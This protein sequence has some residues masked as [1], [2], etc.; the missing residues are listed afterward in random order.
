MS[1]ILI[2]G[3]VYIGTSS[4]CIADLSPPTFAGISFL[5]VESRGQIRAGWSAA[6]DPTPPIRYEVYIQASTAV[7]LFS[8]ANITAITPN[9]QFDIFTMPDGS[10]L[11]NGTTYFVGVRA[12]DGVSNRDANLVSMSVI[13]TGVLTSIDVYEAQGAWS[14]DVS[15]QFQVTAWATKNSNRAK[16]PSEVMGAASYQVFDSAGLPVVALTATV[17]SPTAEGIYVFPPVASTPSTIHDHAQ[18]RITVSIDGEDRVSILP[19]VEDPHVFTMDGTADILPTGELVGSFWVRSVIGIITANLGTGSWQLYTADGTDTGIGDTG[20]TAN[21]DGFF[22]VTPFVFPGPLDE[23]QDFI[24]RVQATVAGEIINTNIVLEG[25]PRTFDPRAIFSINGANQLQATFWAVRAE[26][27][28]PSSILGP[29]SY[30]V[31]DSAGV[32]VPGLT[33]TGITPDGNGYY[34]ITPVSAALLTDLTH[35]KVKV[36]MELQGQDRTST[37]GFTLLGN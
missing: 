18:I 34:H 26:Q 21:A 6:T 36:V 31:Y 20:L 24:V 12:L 16:A 27:Q 17:G 28:A 2:E 25:D 11:V 32:A 8:T 35:Y 14:T 23:T 10:F 30:T 15:N 7:G 4:A 29:A 37:H 9:L 5:D 33:Q 22:V 3:G 19:L 1:D 13:S